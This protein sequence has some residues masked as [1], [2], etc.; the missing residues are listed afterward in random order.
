MVHGEWL[1]L[2]EFLFGWKQGRARITLTCG[3]AFDC[4]FKLTSGIQRSEQILRIV[5]MTSEIRIIENS[6]HVW[7]AKEGRFPVTHQ[8]LPISSIWVIEPNDPHGEL[9]WERK[10]LL[11]PLQKFQQLN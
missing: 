1:Q 9:R 10:R 5:V 11:F 2:Q 6:P 8:E 4:E 7:R 3:E